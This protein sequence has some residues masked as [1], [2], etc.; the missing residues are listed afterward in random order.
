MRPFDLET[1]ARDGFLV[2]EDFLPA[3]DC[4]A[5]RRVPPGS[6]RVSPP[7]VHRTVFST[8]DQRPPTIAISANRRYHSASS[9]RRRDRPADRAGIEQDRPRLRPRSGVRSR[10]AT[11]ELAALARALGLVQ[12]LLLQSMYL[13]KQPHRR[14]SRL[15]PGRHLPLHGPLDRDRLLDCPGRRRPRQWLPDGVARRPSRT[16]APALPPQRRAAGRRDARR[17]AVADIHPVAIEAPR[18]ALVVLHGMLPHASA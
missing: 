2:L 8:A 17:D 10:L 3:G 16:A 6:S 1:Y 11:P 4:D 5:C 12:P 15:A 7:P 18:G 9:S 13:F 14:L